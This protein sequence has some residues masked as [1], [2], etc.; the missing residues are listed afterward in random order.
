M[1]A[2]VLAIA[3][4]WHIAREPVPATPPVARFEVRPSAGSSFDRR[5]PA[6]AVSNDGRT[7]AWSACEGSTGA[8]GLY[9]R[10]LDRLEPSQLAGTD[11]A[12]APFFS[13]DGRWVGFFADG[14]LKKIALAGGAPTTLADAP[15]PGGASWNADGRILFS[16][17]AAGGLSLASDQ[18]GEVTA[19]TTPRADRGEV[20]HGWPSW[21]P[22]GRSAIFTI[23]SSPQPGA[24]GQLAILTPPSSTFRIL[25]GGV[26][27][28]APAGR[29]HLL[30]ASGRDVQ[31]VTFDERTLNL[32]G[33]ADTVLDDLA[34]AGGMAQFAVSASGTLIAQS[35]PSTAPRVFW[36][37]D[38]DRALPSFARLTS[39]VLA[40]D[41]TRVAGVI[42][43]GPGSDIW[44]TRLDTGA[45]TRITYGGTNVSPVWSADGASV[46]FATRTDGAFTLA[47]RGVDDRRPTQTISRGLAHLF[48]AS[49]AADGRVAITTTLPSNRIGI[50]IVPR[51]GGA[52]RL[53]SDGPFDEMSPSL[54]PD[55]AWVAYA[56]DESGRWEIFARRLADGR[57]VPIS[58]SG[59]QR[60][61]W[62]RDGQSIFF[63]DGARLLRARFSADRE[64]RAQPPDVVFAQ[65]GARVLDVS[66]D[67]RF[68]VEQQ[69]PTLDRAIVATEWLRELRQRVPP[70]LTAPR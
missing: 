10:R 4:L 70:P 46:F 64:P 50:G 54:S 52:P 47:V 23:L 65:A 48:P 55:G 59:G 32:S 29:G 35:A 20:R 22:D 56:S 28:A 40:P 41:G 11:R 3:A 24:A 49:A 17:A 34:A 60:P 58:T 36:Q 19:I 30:L 14:K 9:V 61:R 51:D 12:V 45:L 26:A 43:E 63:E 62:S 2:A 37:N 57:R 1:I 21:L 27:R 39:V 33:G 13:P 42:D 25:R 44:V 66:A 69:P 38:P 67:G 16:G 15:S 68:L 5:A 6:F 53:L 8:C 7:I 18:G 31:G